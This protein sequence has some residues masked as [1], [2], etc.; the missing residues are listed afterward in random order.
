MSP[1]LLVSEDSIMEDAPSSPNEHENTSSDSPP[2]F[3]VGDPPSESSDKENRR[4][5]LE[6]MFDD[7]EDDEEFMSSLAQ[8]EQDQTFV[9]QPFTTALL[10]FG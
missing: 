9:L 3:P 2:A 8:T 7:D 1:G 10:T 5:T 4:V 6:D